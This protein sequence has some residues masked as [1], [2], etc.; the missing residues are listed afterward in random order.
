VRG[1]SPP[2]AYNEDCLGPCCISNL[3]KVELISRPKKVRTIRKESGVRVIMM[4]VETLMADSPVDALVD[5]LRGLVVYEQCCQ[6]RSAA[7]FAHYQAGRLGDATNLAAWAGDDQ[8]HV[9]LLRE[10]CVHM[11]VEERLL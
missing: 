9:G 8:Q 5:L 2:L 7:C 3:D 4:T 1:V 6:M 10:L 11:Q